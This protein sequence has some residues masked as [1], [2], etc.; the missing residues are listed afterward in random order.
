MH[1]GKPVTRLWSETEGKLLK[2]KHEMDNLLRITGAVQ[3]SEEER[4]KSDME[5]I[6]ATMSSDDQV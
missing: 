3:E 5:I 1:H 4:Y 6:A 2:E